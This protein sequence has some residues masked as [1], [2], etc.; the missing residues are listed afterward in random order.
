MRT[1]ADRLDELQ[2]FLRALEAAPYRH[3]FFQT[4]RRIEC[5]FADLPRIGRAARP[6][7]EPLRL[8]QEVSLAFAPAPIAAF[9]FGEGGR[10]PRLTQ[11]F[12]GL[13]GP[14]GALPLH[15][16]D[17]ARERLM[18]HGDATLAGFFDLFH[19]RLL[20]LFYRAWAQ[21]R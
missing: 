18:S 12:F 19:H 1:T 11:C 7:D 2:A 6:A 8:G 16:T 17:Y 3:D 21:A 4:L 20:A 15:L 14:N 13:L 9:R 10:P 5:L